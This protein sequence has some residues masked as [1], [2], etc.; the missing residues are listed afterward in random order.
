M[1]II[2]IHEEV[3]LLI[4]NKYKELDTND[5]YLGAMAPDSVNLEFFAPKEDRWTA[6]LRKR[7]LT[8]WRINLRKYYDKNKNNYPRAFILGYITHVLTDI[9]YDDLYYDN[10]KELED[11]DNIPDEL[12]HQVQGTDMEHYSS[13]S[14]YK[15]EI[16][17]KLKAIDKFYEILIITPKTMELFRDKEL[18]KNYEVIEPK[19]INEQLL[20]DIT[21]SVIEELED[22]M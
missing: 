7:D 18:N 11:A 13:I 3:A 15:D 21:N 9:I 8:D 6:H 4:A 5:F 22:Y 10:I 20:V 16:K 1:P 19:Y 14:R 12:S 2:R 17:E